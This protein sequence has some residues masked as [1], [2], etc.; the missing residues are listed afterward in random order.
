MSQMSII[1]VGI[2]L[3]FTYLLFS[4]LC[5][6][7]NELIA[8]VLSLRSKNLKT[9]IAQII[10]DTEKSN[11]TDTI[12]DH[13]LINVSSGKKGPS[14]I[15]PDN[16]AKVLIDVLDKNSNGAVRL[17][18]SRTNICKIIDD[19][20]KDTISKDLKKS[21][22]SLVGQ[23]Y[24]NVDDLQKSLQT[25]FDSSMDRVSGWYKRR[26]QLITLAVAMLLTVVFNVDTVHI[27]DQLWKNPVMRSQLVIQSTHF[28]NNLDNDDIAI[29]NDNI[30]SSNISDIETELKRLP[31]GWESTSI[32]KKITDVYKSFSWENTVEFLKVEVLKRLP[33]WLITMLAISLGAPFWFDI[34]NKLINIRSSGVKPTSSSK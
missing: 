1:E 23:S 25:W 8:Q 4:L 30:Y 31:I 17:A 6:I 13:P 18:V 33:G 20:D 3:A 34:L 2:G 9:G 21:L 32:L 16:F 14:Y 22:K 10:A 26:T 27:A 15:S 5:T 24:K 11:F 7:I 29:D 12:L 28:I 19:I